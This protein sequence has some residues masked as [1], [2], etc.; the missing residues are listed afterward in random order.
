MLGIE[1]TADHSLVDPE[2]AGQLGVVDLLVAH[3][4]AER[5]FRREPKRNRHQA[6]A[7]LRGRGRWDLFAAGQADGEIRSEGI[8]GFFHCLAIVFAIRGDTRK[9]DELDQDAAAAAGR[10]LEEVVRVVEDA[11]RKLLTE[12]VR[13]ALAVGTP[14][15]I[16][17]R[18]LPIRSGAGERLIE[19]SAA[20]IRMETGESVGAVLLMHDVTEVRGLARQMSY[21]ATHDALTGLL[22]R[23]DFERRLEEAT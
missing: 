22:N 19:L 12:P 17:R 20:S 11:D 3:R 5:Q 21:Q 10:P 4:Q 16:G 15:N 13:Q 23:R 1:H 14:L 7:T 2:A 9:I 6:L 8:H 18:A